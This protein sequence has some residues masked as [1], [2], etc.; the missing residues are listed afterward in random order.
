MDSTQD[1]YVGQ[2]TGPIKLLKVSLRRFF[3]KIDFQIEDGQELTFSVDVENLQDFRQIQ[4]YVF[5]LHGIWVHHAC[6]EAPTD[7]E[8]AR[9]WSN[10]VGDAV[11]AGGR[12][13]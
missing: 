12:P 2:T 10:A 5:M 1:P 6:E 4:K 11:A 7:R 3:A 9:I 13:K 8:A